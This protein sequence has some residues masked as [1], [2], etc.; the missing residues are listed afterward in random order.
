MA[1]ERRLA[2]P[3]G[4]GIEDV[5]AEDLEHAD[6]RRG[7]RPDDE[8]SE[9]ELEIARRA[10]QQR[11]GRCEQRVLAELRRSHRVRRDVVPVVP[12]PRIEA[13]GADEE[14]EQPAGKPDRP[15]GAEWREPV[16]DTGN[17]RDEGDRKHC[18][19]GQHHVGG[20]RSDVHREARLEVDVE[21][22]EGDR[23]R[24]HHRGRN[25]I[26]PRQR[27]RLGARAAVRRR[28]YR[29]GRPLY[30]PPFDGLAAQTAVS[31]SASGVPQLRRV[32]IS[33]SGS[34]SSGPCSRRVSWARTT[35]ASWPWSWSR[36]ASSRASSTSP[37]RKRS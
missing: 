6:G 21:E 13:R 15:P 11:H 23:G 9:H 33:P 4:P 12:D 5:D 16:S 28:G 8:R 1:E 26:E 25:G 19:V 35:S 17:D 3:G 24:E 14:D 27:G 2:P 32:S 7:G 18:E 29:H 22:E 10:Q 20:Q 34:A 31:L 37:P 30:W 36:R